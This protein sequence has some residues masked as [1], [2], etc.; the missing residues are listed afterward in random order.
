MPMPNFEQA[1]GLAYEDVLRLLRD[2]VRFER[3]RLGFSQADFAVWCGVP[4]RTYKRFEL[5]ECDSLGVLIRIAQGFGRA[6]GFDMLFPPQPVVM[7]PRRLDAALLSIRKKLDGEV[8]KG[9]VDQ[10]EAA[11]K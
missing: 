8:S 9:G 5:G 11:L 7:A 6:P 10:A 4:L 2:R 3:G 1:N